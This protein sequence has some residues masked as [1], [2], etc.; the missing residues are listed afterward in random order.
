M[1]AERVRRCLLPWALENRARHIFSCLLS[2]L[3]SKSLH[4]PKL[5]QAKKVCVKHV[6]RLHPL[7]RLACEHRHEPL[8]HAAVD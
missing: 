8:H 3:R 5:C 2:H 6:A 4:L 7:V 1:A